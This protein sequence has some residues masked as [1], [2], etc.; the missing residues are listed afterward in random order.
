MG[1]GIPSN[2][3][4]TK[5][6]TV[7][8]MDMAADFTMG[9]WVVAVE[10]AAM[11]VGITGVIGFTGKVGVVGKGWAITLTLYLLFT[12]ALALLFFSDFVGTRVFLVEEKLWEGVLV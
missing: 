2:F 3:P 4:C 11:G 12:G 5:L 9:I 8:G 10:V 7:N 6:Y 1:W